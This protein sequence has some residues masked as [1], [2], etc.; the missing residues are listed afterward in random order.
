MSTEDLLNLEAITGKGEVVE[1]EVKG[2]GEVNAYVIIA[3]LIM[4]ATIATWVVPAGVYDRVLDPATNRQVVVAGSFHSV[5][6]AP[7]GPWEMFKLLQ[8]GFIDA[9]VII[10]FIL[11]VGG[12][13]GLL[14]QTG[15][16]TALIAK[17]VVAFKGK[18][19]ERWSFIFIFAVLYSFSMTF[20][21]A[22][23]GIIFVPFIAMMAISMGYDAILAVGCVCFATALG[24]AGS[25]TGPFNVSI[26]Q[27][28]AGL[29]LYSGLWF[30]AI[31]SVFIFTI[32]AW[33]L[34]RY[35]TKVKKDPSKSLVAGYDFS[36]LKMVEDPEK[37][38]MTGLQKRVML[39]FGVSIVFMIYAMLELKFGMAE[40]TAYF[41]AVGVLTGILSLMKPGQIADG[42]VD[43]AKSLLYPALLVGFARGI[44]TIMDKG[45]ILDS[46]INFLVWPLSHLATWLVPGMMVFV[47]SI[48]N[49]IIPSS[50]AM[51][52]VT[53][54]IM[55]P[56][57]DLLHVQ[58][59]T[60]VLAYQFGDG[61]TNLILPSYSVLIGA[62]GLASVPFAK[63]FKF[64]WP[65]CVILTVVV[66]VLCTLAEV[67][68][69]GP[70]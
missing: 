31:C 55:T 47:Q 16:I 30:R 63:W 45:L 13:F 37:M 69:V 11:V 10:L 52:V 49:L 60:A 8:K 54:P 7:V 50:S 23:Q 22:E 46:L 21:F 53:M 64:A 70:F 66:L 19:Y 6:Q 57:S 12:T 20:G 56:L 62:L 41:M 61:I 35:A 14:A 26:A 36:S 40:L 42:F 15:S 59:Q 68:K 34:L 67:I 5:P 18:P 2:M 9:N 58:R 38:I 29:P 33:Y 48:I 44:Q 32:S 24:Y 43:G 4:L 17:A 25:L 39:L 28:V 65:I 51:A 3:V 1:E 27:Q